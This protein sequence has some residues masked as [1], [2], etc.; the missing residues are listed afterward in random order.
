VKLLKTDNIV[1]AGARTL[2]ELGIAPAALE[3]VVPD[4]L[5]R[6]RPKGQFGRSERTASTA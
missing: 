2:A 5:W 4:Y 1:H 6:F 3:K